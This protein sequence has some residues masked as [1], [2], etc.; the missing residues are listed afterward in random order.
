MMKDSGHRDC[1]EKALAHELSGRTPVNNFAL[2]TAARSAGITVDAARWHPKASAKVSVDYALKTRSDFVKPV[3]DSQVPFADL[4]M[5]IVFP[6]DDYGYSR[7]HPVETSEDVDA[8]A[9][10]DPNVAEECPLFTKVFTEGLEATAAYLP[11]DLHVCGL[12]WGPLTASGYLMGAEEMLMCTFMDPG[13]VKKLV[14]KTAAFVS[15]MQVK[16]LDAGATVIWVA[17]PTSSGDMISPDMYAEFS[18]DATK[19]VIRAAKAFEDVPAFL[20]ICGN[21][22]GTIPLVLGTGADCFSLDFTVDVA[23]AK[24]AA[25]KMS[26]MGNIDPVGMI[27]SGTPD[28]IDR[29]CRR[30][31]QAAGTDGGFI[32]APGCETPQSSPDANVAAMGAAGRGF[33]KE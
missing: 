17:D 33:W 7:G 16:M 24:H 18:L 5:N 23:A 2:V 30:I 27:M 25:D 9:F 11:E 3:L 21:T 8:L 14:K 31:I 4:G 22:L 32:L 15:D 13:L 1:V 12:S 28:S 10:F 19:E 20:H 26:I 6:E 29:E